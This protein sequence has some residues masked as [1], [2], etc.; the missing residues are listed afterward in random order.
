M[1]FSISLERESDDEEAQAHSRGCVNLRCMW[2][3]DPVRM[4]KTNI[5]ADERS[6][7]VT[8]QSELASS[9]EVA[10]PRRRR[11]RLISRFT[12]F[13]THDKL[14][15]SRLNNASLYERLMNFYIYFFLLSIRCLSWLTRALS[16]LAHFSWCR[17]TT[18]TVLK[19]CTHESC[20][21]N[22]RTGENRE[23]EWV[24]EKGWIVCERRHR[25][26]WMEFLLLSSSLFGGW[27]SA[28]TGKKIAFEEFSVFHERVKG[29]F[30]QTAKNAL[31]KIENVLIL[32]R[33][34]RMVKEKLLKNSTASSLCRQHWCEQERVSSAKRSTRRL[35]LRRG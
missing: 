34:G 21:I 12:S 25:W 4:A 15:I 9:R 28:H 26:R 23:E 5:A 18:A 30:Q 17:T 6:D 1:Q 32:P 3:N 8:V 33:N 2:C 20:G 24:V 31:M 16:L 19:F 11:R 14:C 27:N 22:G 7:M 29:T 13:R 10:E 35:I